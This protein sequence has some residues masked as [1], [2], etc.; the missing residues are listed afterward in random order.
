MFHQDLQEIS[1]RTKELVGTFPSPTP[2]PR[3]T[4]YTNTC[5]NQCKH[6]PP[7]LLTAPLPVHSPEDLPHLAC[8]WQ[9]STQSLQQVWHY[10][11]S[12]DNGQHHSEVTPALGRGEDNHTQDCSP[13]RGMEADI[14]SECSP[15]PSRSL[16]RKQRESALEFS[17][18]V[19]LANIWSDA[20]QAQGGPRLAH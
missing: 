7:S 8:L 6:S 9:E 11:S 13:S 1:P 18:T 5:G 16:R 4:R 14:W 19:A 10:A 17:V 20:T 3:Y 15:C 2:Q 12:P